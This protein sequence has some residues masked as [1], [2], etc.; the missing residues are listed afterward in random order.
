MDGKARDYLDYENDLLDAIK[1]VIQRRPRQI[2][3]PLIPLT[4]QLSK[5]RVRGKNTWYTM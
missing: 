1:D 4:R 2:K 3:L 5:L